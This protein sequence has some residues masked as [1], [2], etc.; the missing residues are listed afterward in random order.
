M[1]SDIDRLMTDRN[2]DAI[3]IDGPDGLFAANAAWK[4][5]ARGQ[6]LT[7]RIIKLRGK[8]AQ[9]IYIEMEK[10]EAQKTGL[11]L[12]PMS[13]WDMPGIMKKFSARLDASAEMVRQVFSDLGVRGRVGWY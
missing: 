7:G 5:M 6:H 10:Q 4:Y 8:P 13:R 12:V 3:V 11:A 1:K 2:L 9:L